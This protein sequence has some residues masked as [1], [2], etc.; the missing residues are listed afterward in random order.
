[1]KLGEVWSEISFAYEGCGVRIGRLGVTPCR[2]FTY[3]YD[4]FAFGRW[5]VWVNRN[6]WTRLGLMSNE[7][8][9]YTSRYQGGT[10]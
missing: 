6:E 10:Q 3:N 9:D 8:C 4:A 7:E 2:R 5:E 1:M